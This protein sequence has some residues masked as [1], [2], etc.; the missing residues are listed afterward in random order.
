MTHKYAE[1]DI[2]DLIEDSE[3]ALRENLKV[4]DL[5]ESIRKDG[6]LIP[7]VVRPQNGKYALIS[8]FRRIGALK[9][10][11]RKK[12]QAKVLF[13]VS[14]TE[15]RRISL[16]EN[17][18]RHSLSGW[19]LVSAAARFR[20]K[21]MKNI[22]IAQAFRVSIRTIQRYLLV[23]GAP[24]E[25]R[26]ALDHDDITILQAY[27]AIKKSIPLSELTQHGRSVRYL[28]SLSHKSG[29]SENIRIRRR[30]DGEIIINI[31]YRPG[32]SD[33]DYLFKEVRNRLAR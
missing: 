2:K 20:E 26:K 27:E 14:D 18:E 15:A 32:H 30:A 33:L 11:G 1:I 31:H 29:K 7:I 24:A 23:A 4:D 6:Q 10:L 22:E 21:G 28:R 5:V 8:G 17:L 9:K 12:V 16:L 25:F 3:F 19:E 13:G